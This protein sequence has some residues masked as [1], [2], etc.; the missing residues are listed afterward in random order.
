MELLNASRRLPSVRLHDR[1]QDSVSPPSGRGLASG[2]TWLA[3][4]IHA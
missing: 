2:L 4:A 3:N 1:D